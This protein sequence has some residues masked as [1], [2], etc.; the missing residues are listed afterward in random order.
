MFVS[1]IHARHFFS[2]VN[3]KII[4]NYKLNGFDI[5]LD[6]FEVKLGFG[7]APSVKLKE[8]DMYYSYCSA[9]NLN[10]YRFY[11][12]TTVA[13]GTIMVASQYFVECIEDEERLYQFLLT[14]Y[15]AHYLFYA[16]IKIFPV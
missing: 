1:F 2:L 11:S 8:V 12:P 4:E 5:A 15:I 10:G 3:R 16:R 14:L 13:C 7:D 6:P 9:A